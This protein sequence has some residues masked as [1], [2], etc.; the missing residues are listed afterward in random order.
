MNS[1]SQPPGPY[2]PFST[3]RDG[4]DN[5]TLFLTLAVSVSVAFLFTLLEYY[6]VYGRNPLYRVAYGVF[7]STLPAL[8]VLGVIKLTNFL[9]SWVG[10]VLIYTVFFVLVVLV[11]GT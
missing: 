3:D 9:L 10:A 6:A 1:G 4:M 8:G 2:F 11:Q 7:T 5:R